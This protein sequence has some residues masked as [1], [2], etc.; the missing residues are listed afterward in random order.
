MTFSDKL[1]CLVPAFPSAWVTPHSEDDVISCD[2]R[3]RSLPCDYSR[4]SDMVMAIVFL[5]NLWRSAAG[6]QSARV[7]RFCTDPLFVLR[8]PLSRLLHVSCDA[9]CGDNAEF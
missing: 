2:E 9:V 5:L 3:S 1:H 7:C 6:G 4:Y 8:L